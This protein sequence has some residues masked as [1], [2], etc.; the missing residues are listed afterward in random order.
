MK[1]FLFVFS[2]Q[3]RIFFYS[4]CFSSLKAL[5]GFRYGVENRHA[6]FKFVQEYLRNATQFIQEDYELFYETFLNAIENE[7]DPR[8][9][10]IIFDTINSMKEFPMS[11][12]YIEEFFESIF[13]YFPITFRSNPSDP[14]L[15]TVEDLKSSLGGAISGNARFGDLAVSVLI[16]K[17]S[18]T[19]ASAKIDSLD[20]FLRAV[21]V[22]EP[23]SFAQF[24]Y[25]LEVA[26]F[27]EITANPDAKIQSKALELVRK[28]SVKLPEEESQKWMDKFL[29]EA[30]SAV[31]LDSR[32]VM[33]KSAVLIE[34]VASSNVKNFEYAVN[35]CAEALLK[36]ARTE[37]FSIKGQASRNCLVALFSPIKSNSTWIECINQ[38]IITG[39]NSLFD[40]FDG[41]ADSFCIYLV[42]FS[43]IS[44]I[45]S[46]NC[47][48]QFIQKFLDRSS[49]LYS[50]SNEMKNCIWLASA[51]CP[52]IFLHH[53]NG[54]AN[55]QIIS[56]AA[57]NSQ[58]T[59][60]ALK[61]LFELDQIS[62]I[63]E[64][65][66]KSDLSEASLDLE[67]VQDILSLP[68]DSNSIVKLFSKCPKGIQ[69]SFIKQNV[70]LDPLIIGALP[71]VIEICHSQILAEVSNF[72]N[73]NTIAS[74][75]NKC[76]SLDWPIDHENA[77]LELSA[78][79]G[80]IYRKDPR[81]LELLKASFDRFRV[82]FFAKMFS[83]ELIPELFTSTETFHTK[84]LLYL[85]WLLNFLL[86]LCDSF[87]PLALLIS[88]ISIC[89]ASLININSKVLPAL[90]L[91][92]LN[93]CDEFGE[94]IDAEV[95]KEA[96]K[97]LVSLL[98]NTSNS[99][100]VQVDEL[101]NLALAHSSLKLERFSVIRY[102]A[103]K[104]LSKMIENPLTRVQCYNWQSKVILL[105][106]KD[107]LNDPKRAVRQE[108]ARANNLWIVLRE[109]SV[110]S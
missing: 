16:E 15:I 92:F 60:A 100:S 88:V 34:A 57:S 68:L 45:L 6:I 22:Y 82:N 99:S 90:V 93:L 12:S 35:Y 3:F 94:E 1:S 25:Q 40:S 106:K 8:N 75:Y 55:G 95:R 51:S 73:P 63:E 11:T 4:Y 17:L 97:V 26:L 28:L 59:N 23:I 62:F 108:A 74:L 10:M 13:C 36:I 109:D 98:D 50:L 32:E 71:E 44:S 27:S 58:L 102:W 39:L 2:K 19:S 18:S 103:M 52:K 77:E 41:D 29:R 5:K 96:W 33:S 70:K 87:K 101:I 20:V 83:N 72:S 69:E 56:A 66:S 61:R 21:N 54:I 105:L 53:M 76:P 85:Q 86:P 42:I 31:E 89:P 79:R 104:L 43:F 84:S 64:V 110:F 65:I 47:I 46:T 67:L 80:L 49:G 107:S 78:I 38:N 48:Q 14:N 37:S 81:S 24:R 30:V 9:L 7:K 91:K